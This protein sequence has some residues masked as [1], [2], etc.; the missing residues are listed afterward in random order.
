MAE[1]CHGC[2]IVHTG[3]D[4]RDLAGTPI[5]RDTENGPFAAVFREGCGST[6]VDHEGR[7]VTPGEGVV[8]ETDEDTGETWY[9]PATI[10]PPEPTER[11]RRLTALEAAL[12]RYKAASPAYEEKRRREAEEA[13][14]A[15]RA[16][17]ATQEEIDA[18]EE[19]VLL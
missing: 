9:V 4:T 5:L 11:E 3:Q 19:D 17:G 10:S 14:R 13:G 1:F 2:A 16:A 12:W 15:A 18:V 8:Q 6:Q 7:R